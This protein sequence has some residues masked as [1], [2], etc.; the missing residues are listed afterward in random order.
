[1]AFQYFYICGTGKSSNTR[2][3]WLF[4]RQTKKKPITKSNINRSKT[5]AVKT[6]KLI[7][8]FNV[9]IKSDKHRCLLNLPNLVVKTLGRSESISKKDINMEC[10]NHVVRSTGKRH[11][12]EWFRELLN[13]TDKLGSKKTV[14]YFNDKLDL[15]PLNVEHR[16]FQDQIYFKSPDK[17]K[18]YLWINYL[19]KT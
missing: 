16:R 9:S 7:H 19:I 4:Y 17:E 2:I 5:N 8:S 18:G 15:M 12:S 3:N 14:H 10:R 13:A 11:K 6:F 1:M